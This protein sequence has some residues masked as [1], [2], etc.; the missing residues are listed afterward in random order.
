MVVTGDAQ[1]Q[2]VAG[3][4]LAVVGTTATVPDDVTSPMAQA[5]LE[6]ARA[7]SQRLGASDSAP[8]AG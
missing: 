2:P 7:L 5:L 8:I 6:T 4:T 1:R 3:G